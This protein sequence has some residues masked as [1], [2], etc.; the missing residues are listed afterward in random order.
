MPDPSEH[1]DRIAEQSALGG[2]MLDARVVWDVFDVLTAPSDFHEPKHETIAR[3]IHRLATRGDGTDPIMVTDE[4]ERAGD[5]NKVG[6]PG[7]VHELTSIVP[8]A[9]NAGYY[10]E[11]VRDK[12]TRRRLASA[13][14][15]IAGLAADTR[16]EVAVQVEDA[17]KL[18]DGVTGSAAAD[19]R[20]VGDSLGTLLDDM[21]SPP[22]YVPTPWASVN[23]YIGGLRPGAQ[24]VIGARPGAGKTVMGLNLAV[25][26]AKHGNVA[27]CSLEMS[28]GE[29]QKRLVSQLGAVHMAHLVNNALE[30]DDWDRVAQA[31]PF[32]ERLPIFINDDA[33]AT[34]AKVRAFTRSVARRGKL[35]GLVVD[36]AQLLQAT[37]P[38]KPRQEVVSEFSRSLKVTAKEFGIPVVLLSQLNRASE[39]RMDR[40]PTLA[41][42]RESGSIEQDA[43]VVFLLS[44]DEQD[45]AMRG[46][47]RVLIA[48]NRHGS[49]GET[50]L[51]WLGHWARMDEPQMGWSPFDN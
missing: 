30:P 17:R 1:F 10:A 44:R 49:T 21:A 37:D 45:E 34:V 16:G 33:S 43:D 25:A 11:I 18:V 40:R 38:S 29:L 6:G 35:A 9:A 27:F 51:A 7:Y 13:A 12:A 41:D 4:L 14:A 26:L 46:M 5:L 3:A 36:Y 47:V 22:S 2:M 48:K 31:R 23:D 39:Q 32:I 28:E 19:V 20:P 8:T 42:L 15:G 50:E 24:Y